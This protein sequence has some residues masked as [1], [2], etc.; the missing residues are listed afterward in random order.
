MLRCKAEGTPVT[1]DFSFCSCFTLT[2]YLGSDKLVIN[3][4]SVAV[5]AQLSVSLTCSLMPCVC[6]SLTFY[7]RP[8]GEQGTKAL[9]GL[10]FSLTCWLCEDEKYLP[11]FYLPHCHVVASSLLGDCG[12]PSP[13]W[14]GK[15]MEGRSVFAQFRGFHNIQSRCPIGI[16]FSWVLHTHSDRV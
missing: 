15:R 3:L 10:L 6:I 7:T 12:G 13:C 14:L 8:L 16:C 5:K 4:D 1:W 9:P 2:S 11:L